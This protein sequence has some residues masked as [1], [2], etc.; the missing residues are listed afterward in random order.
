MACI[1][2][3]NGATG[4]YIQCTAA[5]IL[6]IF[7]KTKNPTVIQDFR[8]T[9]VPCIIGCTFGFQILILIRSSVVVKT[10]KHPYTLEQCTN[11]TDF[12]H[13]HHELKYIPSITTNI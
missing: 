12:S 11:K 4:L 9:S 10:Q 1:H 13:T 6:V 2:Q 3:V 8:Y 5:H 7:L